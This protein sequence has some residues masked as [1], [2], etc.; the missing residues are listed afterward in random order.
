LSRWCSAD[1]EE[2]R[3]Y[4]HVTGGTSTA[5]KTAG[6]GTDGTVNL[7]TP[8][9]LHHFAKGS[10]LNES[11]FNHTAR[12]NKTPVLVRTQILQA[13]RKV[14]NPAAGLAFA[15]DIDNRLVAASDK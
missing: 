13:S 3:R 12:I 10:N 1:A 7:T 5:T 8:K 15:E 14:V 11:V 2:C 9:S 4:P 6:E